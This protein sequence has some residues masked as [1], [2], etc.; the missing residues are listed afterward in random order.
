VDFLRVR[1]FEESFLSAALR[2]NAQRCGILNGCYSF[3]LSGFERGG[4]GC[5][6][7]GTEIDSSCELA[8]GGLRHDAFNGA[9]KLCTAVTVGKGDADDANADVLTCGYCLQNLFI[10]IG[11]RIGEE[12]N[13]DIEGLRPG[14][15]LCVCACRNEDECP[16]KNCRKRKQESALVHQLPRPCSAVSR[17]G[18]L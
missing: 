16:T 9:D 1:K 8:D 4:D 12:M 7:E 13:A 6:C 11:E 10:S 15:V 18:L 2:D 17:L 3:R 5:L 14:S